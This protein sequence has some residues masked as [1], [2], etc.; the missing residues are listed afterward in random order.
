[1]PELSIVFCKRLPEGN[2]E[3]PIMPPTS[4]QLEATW[5]LELKR[6]TGTNA[7][8]GLSFSSWSSSVFPSR[9]TSGRASTAILQ[10]NEGNVAGMWFSYILYC[11]PQK[12][13]F[14]QAKRKKDP[15]KRMG[16]MNRLKKLWIQLARHRTFGPLAS[17]LTGADRMVFFQ[18][19][20]LLETRN[21]RLLHQGL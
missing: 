2:P 17:L 14:T 7:T 8:W 10:E 16:A 1:M 13:K 5:C 9:S 3:P 11:P 15:N 20:D 12:K 21:S 4:S 6:C 19:I 18:H